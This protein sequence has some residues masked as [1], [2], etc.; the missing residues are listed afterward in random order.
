ML[1]TVRIPRRRKTYFEEKWLHV[2]IF[3]YLKTKKTRNAEK[4]VIFSKEFY[5]VNEI[6]LKFLFTISSVS[7]TAYHC[8]YFVNLHFAVTPWVIC[9]WKQFLG[10]VVGQIALSILYSEQK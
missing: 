10:D 5:R 3:C 7:V 6:S 9:S 4:T 8:S 1:T 2:S